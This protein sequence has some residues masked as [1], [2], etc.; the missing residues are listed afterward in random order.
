MHTEAGATLSDRKR[1]LQELQMGCNH[2]WTPT[3]YAPI[4]HEAYHIA[5]DPPGTMGVDRQLPMDVPREEIPRWRRECIT[6]GLEQETRQTR[7]DV[8]KVP[9]F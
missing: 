3:V 2:Y 6:C 8:K 7:D 9:V 1:R 5:G 4:I